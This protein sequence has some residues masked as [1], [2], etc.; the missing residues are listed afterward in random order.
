MSVQPARLQMELAQ[1]GKGVCLLWKG[2]KMRLIEALAKQ[3][4][5]VIT[6]EKGMQYRLHPDKQFVEKRNTNYNYPHYWV[7]RSTLSVSELFDI[8]KPGLSEI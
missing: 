8:V 5:G 1:A 2:E 7:L 3:P 6:T 4:R